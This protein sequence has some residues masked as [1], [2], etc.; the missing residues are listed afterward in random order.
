MSDHNG[1]LFR[2]GGTIRFVRW[3]SGR[4]GWCPEIVQG[5]YVERSESGWIIDVDGQSRALPSDTWAVYR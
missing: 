4:D 5:R 2:R 3:I 1:T